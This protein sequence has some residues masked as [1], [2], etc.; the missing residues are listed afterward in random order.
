MFLWLYAGF[1]GTLRGPGNHAIPKATCFD[2]KRACISRLL[3]RHAQTDKFAHFS[4]GLE[5]ML[6]HPICSV[7]SAPSLEP[8]NPGYP[9]ACSKTRSNPYKIIGFCSL[10]S[11]RS[12]STTWHW[13]SHNCWIPHTNAMSAF[14]SAQGRRAV[15]KF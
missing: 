9:F 1:N 3:Q 12:C 4:K 14:D 2:G 5:K 10:S 11:T 6:G 15:K 7:G 13:R 8:G